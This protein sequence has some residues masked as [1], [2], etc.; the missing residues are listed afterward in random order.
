[1]SKRQVE[2]SF[3]ITLPKGQSPSARAQ[4]V[5]GLST[6]LAKLDG[7]TLLRDPAKALAQTTLSGGARPAAEQA[8]SWCLSLPGQPAAPASPLPMPRP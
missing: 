8:L 1:M 4:S 2:I 6:L 3:D 7:A 5:V